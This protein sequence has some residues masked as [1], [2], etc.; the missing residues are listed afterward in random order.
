ME[1]VEDRMLPVFGQFVDGETRC[2]HYHSNKD[3]I[4]IKFKC[5]QKYYSCYKCHLE[6][7]NH[8]IKVWPKHQFDHNAILCG[9]CKTEFTI[10]QYLQMN[11]CKNCGSLFNEGCSLHHHLYFA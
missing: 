11:Q 10:E 3:I 9:V 8:E 7:E 1:K 4:A 2:V 6:A 5:C